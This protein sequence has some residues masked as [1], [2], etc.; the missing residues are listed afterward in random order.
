M[1]AQIIW[2]WL[3]IAGLPAC[4][5][6]ILIQAYGGGAAVAAALHIL[7]DLNNDQYIIDL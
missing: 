2:F 3:L 4:L 1:T 6:Q 7:K 5:L